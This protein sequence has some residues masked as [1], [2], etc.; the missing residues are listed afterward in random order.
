MKIMVA[1]DGRSKIHERAVANS[2]RKLGH[3]VS[4]FHWFQY[5]SGNGIAR[6]FKRI[7]ERL[8]FGPAI[9]KLNKD[10][11]EA[12]VASKPD[13]IFIYRG[14]LISPQ[15]IAFIKKELPHM[16]IVGYNNDDPFSPNQSP[17][18][19]RKF[20]KAL[21][22]YD[23]VFAYRPSNVNDYLSHGAPR[24][25]VLKPW[26]SKELH[27]PV[28]L[29]ESDRK[30]YECEVAF[31]GH[32]EPDGRAELLSLLLSEGIQLKLFGP[33]E[34]KFSGWDLAVKDNPKLNA[35]LPTQMLWG[36]EYNKAILGSKI[37]LCFLSKLNRD[38]YTR[39]CFEIPAVG[40]FLFSEYTDE[41][42][43]MFNE[44]KEA[45]YFRNPQEFLSKIK[46]YLSK[47]DERRSIAAAG[48]LRVTTEGN[49]AE[50]RALQVISVIRELKY[51][52]SKP[53]QTQPLN[54]YLTSQTE[55]SR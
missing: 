11:K 36:E 53:K 48:H 7:Q 42:G 16:V 47:D 34:P 10:F 23:L 3:E 18:A 54:E 33:M 38:K 51:A 43:A 52:L 21:P 45:E 26:Y 4:E 50:A 31:I 49:D 55:K 5:F 13:A 14:V 17:F 35:I 15:L 28:P 37:T 20:R 22:Y 30:T 9:F 41:L 1:G 27:Y 32:Y 12:I 6:L 46:Y 24:S 39:R 19:W 44:G 2:F 29:S 8:I 25:Q 40:G